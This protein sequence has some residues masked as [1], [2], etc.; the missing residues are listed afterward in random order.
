M[1]VFR[2]II[3]MYSLDFLRKC[4]EL[5][6]W[7]GPA[8]FFVANPLQLP[9]ALWKAFD[10]MGLQEKVRTLEESFHHHRNHNHS[11]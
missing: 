6:D 7:Y 3:T 8:Y 5:S 4:R 11:L 1:D 10:K 2:F 9:F